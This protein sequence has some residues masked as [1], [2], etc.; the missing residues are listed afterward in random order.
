MGGKSKSS[1][2]PPPVATPKVETPDVDVA[3]TAAMK[4]LAAQADVRAQAAAEDES[5]GKPASTKLAQAQPQQALT[6][7]PR[8]RRPERD[9]ASVANAA[10][11]G[12]ASSAVLTG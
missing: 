6:G 1:P 5:D 7:P 11:G 2:P 9:P 4:A 8:R 10:T 12:M 3:Q